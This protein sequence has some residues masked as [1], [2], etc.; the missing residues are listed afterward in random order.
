MKFTHR[1]EENL[2]SDVLVL[3]ADG[4]KI[5]NVFGPRSD[6]MDAIEAVL[7]KW[8]TMSK[9]DDVRDGGWGSCAFCQMFNQTFWK[10]ADEICQGCPVREFTQQHSC[11]GSPYDKIEDENDHSQSMNILEYAF[12]KQAIKAYVSSINSPSIGALASKAS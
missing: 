2:G 11:Q 5:S 7:Y 4:E 3:L 8:E 10:N 1:V 12:L 9:L 6:V